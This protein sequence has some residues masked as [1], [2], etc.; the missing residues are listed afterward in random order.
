M[1]RLRWYQDTT[2]RVSLS[3]CLQPPARSCHRP[4]HTAAFTSLENLTLM[5]SFSIWPNNSGYWSAFVNYQDCALDLVNRG[6]KVFLHP[7]VLHK[8]V[9]PRHRK[10]RVLRLSVQLRPIVQLQ[11]GGRIAM[12]AKVNE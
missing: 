8:R 9:H 4:L 5:Y 11:S 12:N 1:Q 10:Q 7:C 3:K 2:R 6:C